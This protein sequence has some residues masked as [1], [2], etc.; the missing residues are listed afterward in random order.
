MKAG[1]LALGF[2]CFFLASCDDAPS[3]KQVAV[4]KASESVDWQVIED[5]VKKLTEE[6]LIKK[7]DIGAREVWVDTMGW[8][9]IDAEMKETLA[10]TIAYHCAHKA[11]DQV[12]FADIYDWQSGKKVAKYDAWG[13][14]VY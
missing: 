1:I 9:L 10:R 14:K 5:V 6:G 11:G 3:E 8:T 2:I 7:I 4:K 12:Y 13:F